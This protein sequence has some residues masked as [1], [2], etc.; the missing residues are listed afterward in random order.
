MKRSGWMQA[1]LSCSL[2][3]AVVAAAVAISCGR[4]QVS[5]LNT[6]CYCEGGWED[7]TG[8]LTAASPAIAPESLDCSVPKLRVDRCDC[9][10]GDESRLFL[11]NDSWFHPSNDYRCTALCKGNS[12]IGVPA[13]IHSEWMDNQLWRQKP[14]YVKELPK[15]RDARTL[16]NMRLVE[17]SHAFDRWRYL[18]RSA[19]GDVIEFG[20]GGYTQLRNIMEHVDV[21]V[22]SVTLVDPLLKSYQATKGCAYASGQFTVGDKTYKT[23]LLDKPVEVLSRSGDL[24]M[25][26][27]V[28]V[29]NVI[30]YSR[31]GL[32][33]LET[34][35]RVLKPGGLL[36][37]HHRSFDTHV[38]SSRCKFA[39]FAIN[40]VQL[41][42]R[43]FD[44]FFE[45][46]VLE[47]FY[48]PKLL[49]T[50]AHQR[51]LHWC[52]SLDNETA[53]YAAVRKRW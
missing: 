40:I 30:E 34:L 50:F 38:K 12:Q 26:D 39:G 17:F 1:G 15:A 20:C 9:D 35:H 8:E 42:S 6:T 2:L 25:Y 29:M 32:K 10:S 19:F 5:F 4:N 24:G 37:F 14:F 16:L 53:Y 47:P 43:V 23:R 27:T 18:N 48:K 33:F 44:K 52:G 36:L 46:F 21:S 7:R 41:T 13:A 49:T 3:L 11:K 45:G 22:S 31:N 28:V 51:S